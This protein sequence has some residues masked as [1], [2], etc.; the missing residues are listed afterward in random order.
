[1]QITLRTENGLMF[2]KLNGKL[3]DTICFD[4]GNDDKI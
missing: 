1:M 4:G 3:V 2:A